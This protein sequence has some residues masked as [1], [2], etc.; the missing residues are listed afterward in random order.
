MIFCGGSFILGGRV[1][2]RKGGGGGG[3]GWVG[4][5]DKGARVRKV[6]VGLRKVKGKG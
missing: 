6:G 2:R 4:R 3:L 5:I 1:C